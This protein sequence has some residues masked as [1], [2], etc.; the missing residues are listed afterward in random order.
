M[1][2]GLDQAEVDELRERLDL[3]ERRQRVITNKEALR[4]LQYEAAEIRWRLGLMSDEEF[5]E[6]E[7]FHDGFTFDF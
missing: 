2:E 1:G 5:A 7:E 4:E 3:L 6:F